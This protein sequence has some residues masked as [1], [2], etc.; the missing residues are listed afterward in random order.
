MPRFFTKKRAGSR[1]GAH[2][3]A[4]QR[5]E[6]PF[7]NEAQEG[8]K[9]GTLAGGSPFAGGS[10]A[11]SL[12]HLHN[13]GGE[14]TPGG[15][16]TPPLHG[17]EERGEAGGV[18]SF[19]ARPLTE[20]AGCYILFLAQ[21]AKFLKGGE[22]DDEDPCQLHRR[23]RI[24]R[25]AVAFCLSLSAPFLRSFGFHDVFRPSAGTRFFVWEDI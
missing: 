25:R 4:P 11:R 16:G 15:G 7:A 10:A 22:Q 21:G 8:V 2:G 24:F 19:G 13:A 6:R 20:A 9:G 3:R 17:S 12:T 5:A 14:R 18:Q 1:G 23:S